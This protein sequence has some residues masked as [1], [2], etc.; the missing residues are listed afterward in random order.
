MAIVVVCRLAILQRM[1]RMLEESE[2]YTLVAGKGDGGSPE[3]WKGEDLGGFRTQRANILNS[4]IV[5][6]SI[7]LKFY[8]S[9]TTLISCHP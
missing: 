3:K 1:T 5:F 6:M 7:L 8:L 9:C 2:E 4:P